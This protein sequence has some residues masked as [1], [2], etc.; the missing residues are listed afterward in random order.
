MNAVSIARERL[1]LA[2]SR[3]RTLRHNRVPLKC[4]H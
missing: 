4:P 2:A 3:Q 1:N